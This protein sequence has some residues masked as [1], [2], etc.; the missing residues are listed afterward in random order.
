MVDLKTGLDKHDMNLCSFLRKHNIPT[1]LVINKCESKNREP[2][3]NDFFELGFKEI[4]KISAEHS[5]GFAELFELCGKYAPKEAFMRV[6]EDGDQKPIKVAIVGRPNAGKSTLINALTHTDRMITGPEPGITRDVVGTHITFKGKVIEI[7]DTAGLRRK[8]VIEDESIEYMSSMAAIEGLKNAD[9]VVLLIDIRFLLENQDL[10]IANLVLEAGKPLVLVI[11]KIDL[12]KPSE[13]LNIKKGFL[14]D[15]QY[16]LGQVRDIP[17]LFISAISYKGVDKI[18]S[19]ALEQHGLLDDR[20]PTFKLNTWLSG[21]LA[22]NQPPSGKHGKRIKI[23]FITQVSMRP[24]VFKIFV[25]LP[26]ELPKSY[27]SYMTNELQKTFDLQG[28]PIKFIMARSYNPYT[29]K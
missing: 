27:L 29:D 9:V 10:K 13:L 4:C 7:L 20:I 24:A 21:I 5:M 1:I 22:A 19:K 12:V 23:K 28:V 17:I 3:L 11:N 2:K 15:I 18:L 26:S 8:R 14:H 16:K 6:G 25:N